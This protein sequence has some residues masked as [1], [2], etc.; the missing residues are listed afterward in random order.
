M[1]P[2]GGGPVPFALIAPFF[3]LIR[4]KKTLE[5]FSRGPYCNTLR[6]FANNY[7]LQGVKIR[8]SKPILNRVWWHLSRLTPQ[9]LDT[10]PFIAMKEGIYVIDMSF[11]PEKYRLDLKRAE[12]LIRKSLQRWLHCLEST[13]D[14]DDTLEL[15]I[16]QILEG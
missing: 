6:L 3:F 15:T 9:L 5:E 14:R 8:E 2:Q 4:D 12:T 16:Q 11:I 1:G 7:T 13:E 10:C